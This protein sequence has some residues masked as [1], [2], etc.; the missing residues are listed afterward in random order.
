MGAA[1]EQE[2]G[3]RLHR[4]QDAPDA[5]MGREENR[6]PGEPR[7]K[8]TLTL[9][10]PLLCFILEIIL[11]ELSLSEPCLDSASCGMAA[12]R[13]GTDSAVISPSEAA[14]RWENKGSILP[15]HAIKREE[16][17]ECRIPQL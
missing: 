4:Y 11:A 1:P 13:G 12:G 3:C 16:L 5:A 8:P 9:R 17:K 15:N 2:K 6:H 10:N 7:F 14:S